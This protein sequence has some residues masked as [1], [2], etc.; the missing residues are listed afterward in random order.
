MTSSAWGLAN[1]VYKHTLYLISWEGGNHTPKNIG[2][3]LRAGSLLA[4][5][6]IITLTMPNAG[7]PCP[8]FCTPKLTWFSHHPWFICRSCC[9]ATCTQEYLAYFLWFVPTLFSVSSL[10]SINNYRKQSFT[11]FSLCFVSVTLSRFLN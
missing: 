6:Q 11:F 7:L 1:R 8:L 3:K 10:L 2:K 4:S 5:V 9:T